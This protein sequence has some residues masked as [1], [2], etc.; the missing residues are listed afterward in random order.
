MKMVCNKFEQIDHS[1]KV[2]AETFDEKEILATL[3][4]DGDLIRKTRDKEVIINYKWDND[5]WKLVQ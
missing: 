3:G 4:R 2:V 1:G 5:T